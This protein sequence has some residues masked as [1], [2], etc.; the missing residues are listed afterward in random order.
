M[1]EQ[2]NYARKA[3]IVRAWGDEPVKLTLHRIAN[4]RCY[5]GREASKQSLCLPMEQVFMFDEA[6]FGRLKSAFSQKD[7]Q[8]LHSLYA[9]AVE[10]FS[11]NKYRDNVSSSHDQEGVSD[12]QCITV[13]DGQ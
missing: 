1:T 13:S 5:V 8:L 10:D 9:A 2:Q 6:L 7:V 3:V 4:N 12:T 11:C